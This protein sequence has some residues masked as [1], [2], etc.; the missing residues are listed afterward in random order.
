MSKLEKDKKQNSI[1]SVMLVHV[2]L[3]E[4]DAE[5]NYEIDYLYEST[6]GSIRSLKF[7]QQRFLWMCFKYVFFIFVL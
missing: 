2:L 6:K 5:H 3:R 7:V 1:S 4:L